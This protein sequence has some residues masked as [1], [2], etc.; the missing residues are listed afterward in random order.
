MYKKCA[1]AF[2]VHALRNTYPY[3]KVKIFVRGAE[4]E[5]ESPGVMATSQESESE[6]TT[7]PGPRFRNVLLEAVI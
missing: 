2:Y 6:L 1:A 4:P 5:S 3:L 7:V